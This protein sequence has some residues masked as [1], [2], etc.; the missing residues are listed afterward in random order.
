MAKPSSD[1]YSSTSRIEL[2]VVVGGGRRGALNRDATGEAP[3][4]AASGTHSGWGSCYR[5]AARECSGSTTG[6]A[7]SIQ[8]GLDSD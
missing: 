2:G 1:S 5:C 6:A 8:A 7:G 4:Q 3:W